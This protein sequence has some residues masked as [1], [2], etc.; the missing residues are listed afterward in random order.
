MMVHLNR[1]VKFLLESL[2]EVFCERFKSL[3]LQKNLTYPQIADYLGLKQRVVKAYAAGGVKPDY[4]G[5]LALADLFDA[6]G[7]L[8]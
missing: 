4:Y 6:S 7:I 1:T 8:R 2:M 5:L 3:K